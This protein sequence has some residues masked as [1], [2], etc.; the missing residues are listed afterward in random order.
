MF[1]VSVIYD[2]FETCGIEL[3]CEVE[4]HLYTLFGTYFS[5]GLVTKRRAIHEYIDY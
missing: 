3:T 2:E 1:R 4:F 5:K